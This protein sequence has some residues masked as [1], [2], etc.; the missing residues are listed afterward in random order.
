MSV[1]AICCLQMFMPFNHAA[2]GWEAR[3]CCA[4]ARDNSFVGGKTGYQS[5]QGFSAQ[6]AYGQHAPTPFSSYHG[7]GIQ[8]ESAT[9]QQPQCR[10]HQQ[11]RQQQQQPASAV[12]TMQAPYYGSAPVAGFAAG[13]EI[14]PALGR[15]DVTTLLQR[16]GSS[17]ALVDMAFPKSDTRSGSVEAAAAAAYAQGPGLLLQ[18]KADVGGPVGGAGSRRQPGQTAVAQHANR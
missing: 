1:P 13:P 9:P 7:W 8:Q 3:A 15:D 14:V 6:A 2:A 18:E 5:A 10:Q 4:Q 17:I 11:Q 16:A 12:M